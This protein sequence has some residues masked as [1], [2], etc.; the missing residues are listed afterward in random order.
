[1]KTVLI[2]VVHTTLAL[3]VLGCSDVSNPQ[4][5]PDDADV[6]AR[7][8]VGTGGGTVESEDGDVSLEIPAGA[9]AEETTHLSGSTRR[10]A[11]SGRTRRP[12]IITTGTKQSTTA[13]TS[14]GRELTAGVCQA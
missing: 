4:D 7:S 12:M 5:S 10:P 3:F 13:G 6:V 8:V 14:P 9:L 2:A 1:M 11:R